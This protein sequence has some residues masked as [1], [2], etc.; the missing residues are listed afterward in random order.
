MGTDDQVA[1]AK[2]Q[3]LADV[4]T[5]LED[6]LQMVENMGMQLLVS[7]DVMPVEKYPEIIKAISTA[8]VQ[9]AAKKLADPSWPWVQWVTSPPS[10]TLT[11][12]KPRV[13][14]CDDTPGD[15]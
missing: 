1:G 6:P 12:C 13:S 8:D 7:G 15:F 14:C 2:N 5:I 11:P 9:A 10:H 3:L 4:Y